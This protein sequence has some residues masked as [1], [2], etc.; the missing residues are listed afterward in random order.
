MP[1]IKFYLNNQ[2]LGE[3]VGADIQKIQKMV[4]QHMTQPRGRRLVEDRSLVDVPVVEA[5]VGEI[6]E[7]LYQELIM[8][9]ID[10]NIARQAAIICFGG[11]LD[12]ALDVYV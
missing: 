5:P 7:N 11:E 8:L 9:D 12:A 6:D 4:E 3:V 10:D 2:M 1:T